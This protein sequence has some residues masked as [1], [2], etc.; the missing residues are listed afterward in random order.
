MMVYSVAA[1]IDHGKYYEV[2][3]ISSSLTQDFEK[4]NRFL[5]LSQT[6][7]VAI[8]IAMNAN[9]LVRIVS[10]YQGIDV[11]EH[12]L[13]IIEPDTDDLSSQKMIYMKKARQ[14][15]SHQQANTSGLMMYQ[16]ININ[17]TL[18]DKGYFIHDD[19][20]EEVYLQILETEDELLI[21]KLEEYLN[22][23][24]VIARSSYLE[25]LYMTFYRDMKDA[26]SQEQVLEIYS[27]IIKTLT[28]SK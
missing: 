28:S 10:D 24:D 8:R 22:A 20:K 2:E 1:V 15:V 17:N 26:T 4:N 18:C 7:D 16:Y 27:E 23:R 9:K 5:G 13:I 25:E 3:Y 21:D 12:D 6:A 11:Q 14:M 19:N